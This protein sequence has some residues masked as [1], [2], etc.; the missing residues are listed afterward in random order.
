MDIA[1]LF[2]C[3]IGWQHF[4]GIIRFY[5]GLV[6]VR[7]LTAVTM[8]PGITDKSCTDEFASN[9][10]SLLTFEAIFID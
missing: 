9:Y 8:L 3:Y 2:L 10:I 6:D 5:Q 4:N 7:P 1:S